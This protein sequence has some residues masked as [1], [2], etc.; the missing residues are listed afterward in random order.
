MYKITFKVTN[1]EKFAY[2]NRIYCVYKE[3]KKWEKKE[4]TT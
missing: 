1:Y 2:F 4:K 3:N